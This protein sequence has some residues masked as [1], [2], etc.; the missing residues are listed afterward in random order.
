MHSRPVNQP[1]KALTAFAKCEKPF[2]AASKASRK[3]IRHHRSAATM[4]PHESFKQSSN[5]LKNITCRCES[6]EQHTHQLRSHVVDSTQPWQTSSQNHLPGMSS[7]AANS[8]Q[9]NYLRGYWFRMPTSLLGALIESPGANREAP[10]NESGTIRKRNGKNSSAGI[11]EDGRQ[12][13]IS[14]IRCS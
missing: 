1:A 14:G 8:L 13:S 11:D 4:I 3:Q 2:R 6:G 10:S 7:A 5:T 12:R 9:H